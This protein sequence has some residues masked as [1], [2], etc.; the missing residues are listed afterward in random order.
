M[1]DEDIYD[2]IVAGMG[3]AGLV[4][5]LYAV[6]R[7]LKTKVIGESLGGQQALATLIENYPGFEEGITGFELSERMKKQAEKFGCEFEDARIIGFDL[8]SNPKSVR[9]YGGELRKANVIIL[10]TGASYRRLNAKGEDKFIGKGVSYCTICD[11]PLFKK[12]RVAVVGGG[13]SAV[14]AAIYINNLASEV[15]LI[16][17]RGELRA[18]AANQQKLLNETKVKIL[19]DT[20]IDEIIGDNFVRKIRIRNNKTNETKELEL[21]GLFIEIGYIPSSELLKTAGIEVDEKGFVKTNKKQETNIPGVFAAGDITGS[22]AQI[23]MCVGEGSEA[24]TEAYYY[25][26]KPKFETPD[27]KKLGS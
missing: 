11:G 26:R 5:G 6:R 9:L 22:L 14:Q 8:K 10:A 18:E 1:P 15:Y 21:D 25:L 7:A 27:Y 24:A 17:R 3:P 2:V 12:K 13:D 19:W 4:A 23:T 20:E 16:H